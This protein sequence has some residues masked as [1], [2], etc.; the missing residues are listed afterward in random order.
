MPWPILL[1]QRAI[2]EPV[3]PGDTIASVST[4]IGLKENS[5][6][7]T[8]VVY[9]ETTGTNQ[10]GE[11]AIAYVRWV[12]VRK[13]DPQ[14][15]VAEASV[16]KLPDAIDAGALELPGGVTLARFDTAPLRQPAS[17]GR[18]QPWRED[19]PRRRQ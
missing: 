1:R 4:V 13:R 17:L 6:R 12:M 10:H 7:Q 3:Y 14:A 2:P 5:N 11:T 18:L 19:R 8:G 15:V 9:V 16:P